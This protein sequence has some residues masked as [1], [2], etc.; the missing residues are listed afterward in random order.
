[1]IENKKHIC[2]Y[3]GKEFE[4]GV[5][6]GG[7]VAR[8]KENPKYKDIINTI[9][10]SRNSTINKNNPLEEHICKC[11]MCGNDYKVNIRHNQFLKGKYN[12]T[13]S[14]E[15]SHKLTVNKTNLELKNKHISENS[16]HCSPWN[17]GKHYI[18]NRQTK[19]PN[20]TPY[21]ICPICG[22]KFYNKKRKYCSDECRNK[23]KFIKLS[24][25]AKKRNFGGYHPNSIKNHHHGNYKGIHCDSSWEL[26]YLVYCLEHNIDIKRC[27][28][29]RYYILNKKKC[30][31]FPD[32]VVNN[33][34]IEIKGYF[35]K[36]AQIKSEQN[37]DIKVLLYDDLKESL[38]YTINK[39]GIKFW[40]V[41]YD[42]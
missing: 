3:C 23:G 13:C 35:S 11:E 9:V 37:P 19:N 38:E 36:V 28:E 25:A 41:L 14:L 18:N 1:M 30:K 12:K 6:L 15:C 2:K 21:K 8:C 40:E 27:T 42:K 32:F 31:Y 16:S 4:T 39:Y 10:N 22:E 17:K 33:Q 20:W 7:H 34:I 24:N 26:A 5:K 29:V